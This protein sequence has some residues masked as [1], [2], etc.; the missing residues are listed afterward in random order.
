LGYRLKAYAYINLDNNICIK[1]WNY[2]NDDNPGFFI[3]NKLF[4]I[5]HWYFDTEDID[6]V[7]NML[8]NMKFY[9]LTKAQ[10]YEFLKNIKFDKTLVEDI[11]EKK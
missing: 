1:D 8:Y 5:R 2:I 3:Q 6:S 4:I 10:V 7:R 9:K 11:I